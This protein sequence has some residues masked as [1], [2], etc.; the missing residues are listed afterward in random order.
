VQLEGWNHS[1]LDIDII[2]GK[3]LYQNG[4][5]FHGPSFQGVERVLHV[6]RGKL[7]TRCILPKIDAH[8]Q[9]QFPVQTSNPF[10]Y[11]AI[12]QCLLIWSQHFYQAPCLPSR[13]QKL[14]Q[15]RSIPFDTPFEVNMEIQSQTDTSVVANISVTDLDGNA[16]VQ[17]T[18]LE[19]TIST[20]LGQV[21]EAGHANPS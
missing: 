7:V 1:P 11:D 4:T 8:H 18:G 5:L 17:F 6:S 2:P 9:G 10:I 16:F 19:G 13:L 21:L 20:H 15:Y 3:A 12:V 14:E